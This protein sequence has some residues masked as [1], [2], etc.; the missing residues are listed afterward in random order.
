MTR[1]GPDDFERKYREEHKPKPVPWEHLPQG[2]E[3]THEVLL[4]VNRMA[5]WVTANEKFKRQDQAELGNTNYQMDDDERREIAA[6][7]FQ[8]HTGAELPAHVS[9]LVL[10]SLDELRAVEEM[11]SEDWDNLDAQFDDFLARTYQKRKKKK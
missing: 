6:E 7:F 2:E 4:W 1:G 10:E 3:R 9:T 11:K 5:M 8:K